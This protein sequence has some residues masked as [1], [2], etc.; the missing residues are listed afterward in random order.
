MNVAYHLK[1]LGTN[2]AMI[3]RIG[4][5]EYGEKLVELL[6]Q[7]NISTDYIQ[8]DDNHVASMTWLNGRVGYSGEMDSGSTWSVGLNVQ[9]ILDREPPIFGWTNNTYDQYGRRYNINFNYN[10]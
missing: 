2:P 1:K 10:Y 7:N 3:T 8:V 6:S 4:K 9:N 5:D